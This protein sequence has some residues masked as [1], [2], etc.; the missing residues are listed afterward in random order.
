MKRVGK[1]NGKPVVEG[2]ANKIKN[3]IL[4]TTSGGGIELKERKGNT[5][6]NLT[7]S[8]GKCVYYDVEKI[9][10]TC[11]SLT[12]K[13]LDYFLQFD[14]VVNNRGTVYEGMSLVAWL[15]SMQS[16][17]IKLVVGKI[18]VTTISIMDKDF[19]VEGEGIYEFFP[20]FC[21]VDGGSSD[22]DMTPLKECEITEEE[23]NKRKQQY[24]NG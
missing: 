13:G 24:L 12:E 14:E 1:L 9:A 7:G 5:L 18:S 22:V 20:K 6:S 11:T 21:A 3:Q 8:S 10:N 16:A 2:D 17:S 19:K 15:E 4:Y 23:Y